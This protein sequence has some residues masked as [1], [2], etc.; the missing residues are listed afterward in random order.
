VSEARALLVFGAASGSEGREAVGSGHRNK[1]GAGGSSGCSRNG[2]TLQAG[3][4]G[5]HW[6]I[7]AGN[8]RTLTESASFASYEDAEQ[9]AVSGLAGPRTNRL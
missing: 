7:I 6:T 9:A 2:C 5:V 8:G 1:A 3:V 4:D